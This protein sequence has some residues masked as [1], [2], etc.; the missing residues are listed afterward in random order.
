MGSGFFMILEWFRRDRWMKRLARAAALALCLPLLDGCS[1][2]RLGYGQIDTVAVWIA[3]DYFDLEPKQRQEFLKRFERLHEWHRYEQLPD[4]VTFLAGAKARIQHGLKREDVAWL[5]EGARERYRAV[6]MRSA[7]D[8]AALLLTMTP[9]QLEALQRKWNQVNRRFVREHLLEESAAE[10]RRAGGRRALS[11]IQDWTGSLTYE[12]E[13]KIIALAGELPMDHRL[14]HED[15]MRRQ[16]EF[17]QLMAQR[18][19]A[20]HF[21]SRFR[22]WLLNWE[23]GRDP[24]FHQ[25]FEEWTRRQ[26]EFYVA[27]NGLLTPQQR[28]TVLRRVQNYIDDFARL[29]ERPAAQADAS[30]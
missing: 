24:R 11:R 20:S 7:D 2:V 27:V 5:V 29:S 23:E 22:H 3:D 13:Q 26:G 30:R 15:R 6:I 19:D 4:Y 12:Q 28:A 8:G 18:G 10:Q 1:M 9:A 17:M 16:R 25:I 14:R 21:T